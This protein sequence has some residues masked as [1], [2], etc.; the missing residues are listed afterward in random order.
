MKVVLLLYK[1]TSFSCVKLERNWLRKAVKSQGAYYKA[2]HCK[3]I[4][5]K[6]NLLIDI[7]PESIQVSCL[8]AST[9]EGPGDISLLVGRNHFLNTRWNHLRSH[10]FQ[11]QHCLLSSLQLLHFTKVTAFWAHLSKAPCESYIR[12]PTVFTPPASRTDFSLL[13]PLTKK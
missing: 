9:G 10:L 2:Y 5:F 8:I 13:S 3:Q 6:N 1:T 4:L 12:K 11:W 7:F